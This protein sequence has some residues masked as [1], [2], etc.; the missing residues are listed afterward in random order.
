MRPTEPKAVGWCIRAR[1]AALVLVQTAADL[2][3]ISFK[4][5]GSAAYSCVLWAEPAA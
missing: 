4:P 3:N 1:L 2:P 5:T